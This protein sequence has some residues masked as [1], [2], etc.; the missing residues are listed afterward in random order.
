MPVYSSKSIKRERESSR[1]S[2]DKLRTEKMFWAFDATFDQNNEINLM[3]IISS[4]VN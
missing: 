2:N 3:K 4:V 1:I